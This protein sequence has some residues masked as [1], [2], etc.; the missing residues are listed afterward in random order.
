MNTMVLRRGMNI[1]DRHVATIA[2]WPR[3]ESP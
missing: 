2:P 3:T 1:L